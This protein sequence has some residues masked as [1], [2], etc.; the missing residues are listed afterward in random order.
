M[1]ITE[2]KIPP[3]TRQYW[4][5]ITRR[6]IKRINI[7]LPEYLWEKVTMEAELTGVHKREIV[8]QALEK[9]FQQTRN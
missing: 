3:A 5:N 4:K 1:Q 9:Y 7:D 2:K 8:T 6:G